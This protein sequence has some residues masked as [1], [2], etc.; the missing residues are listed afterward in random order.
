M[1]RLELIPRGDEVTSGDRLFVDQ[2]LGPRVDAMNPLEQRSSRPDSEASQR[3]RQDAG[4]IYDLDVS[5]AVRH[6][7]RRRFREG[8]RTIDPP[9]LQRALRQLSK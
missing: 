8:D 7:S 6:R 1:N 3:D 4:P 5:I 2:H 9:A